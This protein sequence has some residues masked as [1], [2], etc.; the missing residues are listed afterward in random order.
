MTGEMSYVDI[1]EGGEHYE[2]AL[3]IRRAAQELARRTRW[4]VKFEVM[5][6]F[7]VYQGPYAVLTSGE[8]WS[9]YAET[10][11]GEPAYYYK[12]SGFDLLGSVP[13]IAAEL[14]ARHNNQSKEKRK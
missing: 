10:E 8:L 11:T 1:R 4:L 14:R 3:D 6:P 12:G 5:R 2:W 7:D 9:G 13:E